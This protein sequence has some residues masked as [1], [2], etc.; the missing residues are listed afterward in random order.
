MKVDFFLEAYVKKTRK[1]KE[2]WYRIRM[3]KP[4]SELGYEAGDHYGQLN[5][6]S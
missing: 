2:K 5:G 4:E 6:F 1:T 3:S